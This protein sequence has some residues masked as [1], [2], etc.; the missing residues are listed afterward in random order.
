M[1]S[2]K[3][4]TFFQEH[5]KQFALKATASAMITLTAETAMADDPCPSYIS[6][7]HFANA[8]CNFN[9][10]TGLSVT[11]QNTGE[12]GS[13]NMA[14]YNPLSPSYIAI[15]AGGTINNTIGYAGINIS[16]SSLSDGISNNGAINTNSSDIAIDHASINGGIFNGGTMTSSN[17]TG[18]L[19]NTSTIHGGISN[20][21]TIETNSNFVGITI[22]NSSIEGGI[23]NNGLIKAADT[24]DAILIIGSINIDGDIVNNSHGII[25]SVAHNGITVLNTSTIHGNISNYGVISGGI[26]GISIHNIGIVDGDIVNNNAISG[27]QHGI[28]IFSSASVNRS[29][30]NNGTINGGQTGIAISSTSTVSGGISNSGI[31]QGDTNAIRIENS[32]VGPINILGQHARIIGNVE[33]SGTTVNIKEG[34]RFTSEGIFRVDSFKIGS[35]ALFNMAHTIQAPTVSNKGTLAITDTLQTIDGHYT[36]QTGGLFQTGISKGGYGQLSVTGDVTLSQNA[37]IYVQVGQDALLHNGDILSDIISGNTLAPTNGFNVS[38]NSYIWAFVPTL[39]NANNGINLTATINPEA[40]KVC[41]GTYC[42]GAATAI[43]GQVA[44]GNPIFNPYMI[45]PTADALRVA[46]SQATPE[47]TNENIQTLQLITRSILDVAPMWDTLHGRSSGDAARY[48][49][50]KIWVKPYGA[51]MTQNKR[52]TIQGFNATAYGAV[53]GKDIQLTND[54]LFGGGFAAGGDT[55]HGKSVL[56]GQSIN[57]QAYQ[58]MFYGAKTLPNHVYFAG[59]GLVGYEL[60]DTS[61]SIP[62]YAS[63][64]KGSYNS[65]FTNIRAEA[66]WNT[67]ALSPN[68][69]FTPALDAS[70]LFIN[71][72]SY[73]ESGSLMDL[74]VASNHNSSLILGAY[75]NGAYHLTNIHNQ[76]DLTLTGYTGCAGDVIKSQPNVMSTF[77]ANSSTFSTFGIQ[78]NGV[79]FRG[80]VGLALTN[81]TSPLIIEL[82]YNLQAG[83]NAYSNMGAATIKYK[84]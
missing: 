61:R 41:Q 84:A 4:K 38:D 30:S 70:Y 66:G 46:A 80:G 52:N 25:Q 50:G 28:S 73:Q 27:D 42:Q 63:T 34:A 74:S 43:I 32:S 81:P 83:N 62:L 53:I 26:D 22:H 2:R 82:N 16:A 14:S 1:D 47:L 11:V 15:N 6:N 5:M 7:T 18:I 56:S 39:N 51:S 33:A 17:G 48:Q 76:H 23:T 68:F 77:V 44:A 21:G 67:Y 60:N 12:V 64:A 13:I 71:Q 78:F 10:F 45:L 58:G 19:I 31:I 37:G 55:M 24:G 20:N 57:S 65:W 9:L 75:A 36:Q 59:Q 29:I 79:V 49:P 8:V 69:I 54:W 40:Y 35:N 3:N 72:N